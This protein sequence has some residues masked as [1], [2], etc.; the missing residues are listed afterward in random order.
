MSDMVMPLDA[1]VRSISINRDTPH[2]LFLGAGASVS[3][4]IPSAERC[5]MEWKGRMFT[6]A[7]PGLEKEVG[8]L[9]LASVQRRIQIWL[10]RQAGFPQAGAAK[11]YS[12]YCERCYTLA[13]DRRAYFQGLVKAGK[14]SWGLQLDSLRTSS[15]GG[16]QAPPALRPQSK[17]SPS[18]RSGGLH[19]LRPLRCLAMKRLT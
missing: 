9:F 6:S 17:Y 4:G 2:S 3:S 10:D 19:P 18:G 12:F 14:Q 8:H 13:D 15:A 16:P 11:E 7:N 5:I 1:F